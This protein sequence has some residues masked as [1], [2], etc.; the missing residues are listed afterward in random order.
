M[1]LC[2]KYT[3]IAV[4]S[5]WHSSQIATYH[6]TNDAREHTVAPLFADSNTRR[7]RW[8]V[9]PDCCILG[10]L[11]TPRIRVNHLSI[12]PGE[13]MM[14]LLTKATLAKSRER[15][16]SAVV[17]AN[18]RDITRHISYVRDA[19]TSDM[20]N[21]HKNSH[22]YKLQSYLHAKISWFYMVLN[23]ERA[24][25]YWSCFVVHNMLCSICTS[26]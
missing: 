17:W 10:N 1:T 14:V 23:N 16:N 26:L 22:V 9:E 25:I 3:K 7:R 2:N 11:I 21:V 20:F 5:R 19:G 6:G 13:C 18:L 12:K 24:Y 8:K 15:K 4:C